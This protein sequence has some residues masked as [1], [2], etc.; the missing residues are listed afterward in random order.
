[1]HFSAT[2]KL[3]QAHHTNFTESLL[4]VPHLPNI[5]SLL[6][7]LKPLLYSR[8]LLV[9]TPF[10]CIFVEDTT[11]KGVGWWKIPL[12]RVWVCWKISLG[13]MWGWWKRPLG[14]VWVCWKIS[15]GMMWGWWN[16]PLGRVWGG[17]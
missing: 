10:Y 12:G 17:G 7:S 11:G 13:M 5:V 3:N 16:I 6:Q 8:V 15:L 9:P 14:R 1:M 4:T 2:Q